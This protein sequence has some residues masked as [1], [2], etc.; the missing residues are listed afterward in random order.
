[1]KVKIEDTYE[2]GYEA[3]RVIEILGPEPDPDDLDEVRE[4]TNAAGEISEWDW[5]DAEVQPHTGDG[6]GLPENHGGKRTLE[7]CSEAEIIEADNPALVGRS[8]EWLG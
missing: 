4:R 2:D 7:A 6:H 1:M 5:W 3:E 8:Y